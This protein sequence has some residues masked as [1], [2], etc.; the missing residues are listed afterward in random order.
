MNPIYTESNVV[1]LK[2]EN[3]VKAFPSRNKK[4]DVFTAVDNVSLNFKQGELTTLLGPSG[5]GKT[6]TLRMLA[7]FEFPTSGEVIVDG[8]NITNQPPNKRDMG[9]VFQNYALFPHLTVYENVSYGLRIKKVDKEEIK[10]R[11]EKVLSLMDLEELKDRNPSRI[12]GGQQQRVAIARAII[13]EPKIL[14]F[15]EPL[16][17]LDSKLRQYMRTEIRNLQRRLGI[18][19]IYV[20]HDQ[21]E[22]MAISDQ[23]VIL[24]EGK[25]QQVGSPLDIYLNPVNR[26][27][28]NFI[29]DSDILMATVADINEETVRLKLEETTI[30]V[31][32]S[33]DYKL[34]KNDVVH[35]VMKPEFWSITDQ[36][37]FLVEIT[38]A[39]FL[40]SHMEY[41]VQIGNQSFKFFDYYHYENGQKEVG[42]KIRLQLRSDLVKIL[43]NSIEKEKL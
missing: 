23:V 26:F 21:E 12:S 9:M 8:E 3:V 11:T 1:K 29:G 19:S 27:V 30:Q 16:S 33:P 43:D 4:Q 18:T 41:I 6:T 14:L 42:S 37:N 7:G 22:A 24:D 39:I 5:C 34:Q 17:N 25:I 2:I 15:D 40:G 38:Q 13:L 20:T 32:N 31:K 35:C 36:G 10:S 28:A